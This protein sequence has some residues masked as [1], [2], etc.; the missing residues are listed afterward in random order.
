M[1]GFLVLSVQERVSMQSAPSAK[2][3]LAKDGPTSYM[4][5]AIHE[6]AQGCVDLGFLI[7]GIQQAPRLN[8][9]LQ[10]E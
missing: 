2:L 1:M 6:R 8:E 5:R 9:I 7:G 3:V 10:V 4:T